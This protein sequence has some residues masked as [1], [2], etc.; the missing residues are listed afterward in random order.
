MAKI[1]VLISAT[2]MVLS[3]QAQEFVLSAGMRSTS[4]SAEGAPAGTTYSIT[5]KNG[6]QL[7]GMGF[8]SIQDKF[9]FRA[10]FLYTQ[11]FLEL[12]STTG[13]LPLKQTWS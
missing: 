1:F 6:L 4:A 7:G 3:A 13:G 11:R 2:V 12:T 5:S 9:L 10:G 8:F